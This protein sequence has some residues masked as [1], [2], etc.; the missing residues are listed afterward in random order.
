MGSS[1]SK[2]HKTV[3][4]SGHITLTESILFCIIIIIIF[5]FYLFYFLLSKNSIG[6]SE[7]KG[8]KTVH[9]SGHM[10]LIK[11]HKIPHPNK[12]RKF[13]WALE[14]ELWKKAWVAMG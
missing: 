11:S 3:H 8:P 5:Y 13:L 7:S 10:T 2:G 6:S 12:K 9:Y 1:E 4:Y 14:V